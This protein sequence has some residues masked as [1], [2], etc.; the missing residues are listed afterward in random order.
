MQDNINFASPNRYFTE[1][2]RWVSCIVHETILFTRKSELGWCFLVKCLYHQ[3]IMDLGVN[4][5][6]KHKLK[7]QFLTRE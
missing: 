5:K 2:S 1:N 6:T 4:S 7:I 3:G